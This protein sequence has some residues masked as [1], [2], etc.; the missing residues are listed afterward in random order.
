MNKIDESTYSLKLQKKKLKNLIAKKK[1]IEFLRHLWWKFPKF[2]NDLKWKK[3]KGKDNKMRLKLKGY[4]PVVQIGYGTPNIIKN[5]HPS[6][7]KPIVI[8]NIKDFEN[9]DPSK[10]IVYIASSVGLKKRMEL[11]KFA[12]EHGFKVANA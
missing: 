10:H 3:P 6:G 1:R 2:Q 12:E 11:I 9:L 7:Y 8:S 5:L 4:P